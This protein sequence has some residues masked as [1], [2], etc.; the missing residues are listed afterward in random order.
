MNVNG[1]ARCVLT[2]SNERSHIS[3]P[4]TCS[5]VPFDSKW[6]CIHFIFI[7]TISINKQFTVNVNNFIEHKVKSNLN[8]YTIRALALTYK[9]SLAQIQNG[10]HRTALTYYLASLRNG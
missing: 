3:V 8:R 5:P 10:T 1:D 6:F 7:T 2:L 9:K 4:I